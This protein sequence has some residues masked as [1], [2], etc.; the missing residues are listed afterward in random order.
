MTHIAVETTAKQYLGTVA[1][2]GEIAIKLVPKLYIVG[3]LLA[4]VLNATTTTKNFP[5]PPAGA[6]IADINPPILAP[7]SPNPAVQVGLD[8]A[9]AAN[10]APMIFPVTLDKKNPR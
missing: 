5:N 8:A 9:D 3:E 7:D 6:K 2:I 4:G 1:K 10:A